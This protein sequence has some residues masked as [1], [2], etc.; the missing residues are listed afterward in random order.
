MKLLRSARFQLV[1]RVLLGGYFVYASLDKIAQPAAF[2]KI[3]YSGRWSGPCRR[4]SSRS[5]CPGSS[6]SPACCSSRGLEAADGARDR[7]AA[8]GVPGCRDVGP[9]TR[10]RRR[11]LRLHFPDVGRRPPPGLPYW[12]RGVGWFLITRNLI[13]LGIALLL[14]GVEPTRAATPPSASRCRFL[15]APPR[16]PAALLGCL[17]PLPPGGEW[18]PPAA[19]A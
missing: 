4:T 7:P 11:E 8:R 14:A 19:P 2:A 5:C 17:R 12:T 15:S 6:C 3:V 13:L 9:G 18:T 10:H 16:R 1:A